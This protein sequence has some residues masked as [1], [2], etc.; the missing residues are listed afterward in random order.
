MAYLTSEQLKI[1]GF[2][3]LGNN[4]K[5]SDKASIYNPQNIFLD[6]DC[7]ID[8]FCI[9]SAGLNGIHIG[10]FAHIAAYSSLMGAAEI[11]LNDF[12]GISSRV[13]IY[14]SNDDY[15]GE[16]LC[17]PT[18]PDWSRNVYSAPVFLDRHVIVGA[19]SIILPGAKLGIGVAI[20]ALSLVAGNKQYDEFMIYAGIP[21]KQIKQR[22]QDLLNLE[23]KILLD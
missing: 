13:S 22:K 23:K 7:R 6:D 10:K 15:S 19:G 2:K 17:H 18:V 16:F 9:L 1:L 12:S 3:Y 21:A 5:I 20:G 14:S 11:Y 8:D 4:V